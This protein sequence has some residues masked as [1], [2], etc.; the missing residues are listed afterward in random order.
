MLVANF[1]LPRSVESHTNIPA[2]RED[3]AQEEQK[4]EHAGSDPTV[5]RVW[6]G[7]VKVGLVLLSS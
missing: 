2:L 5:G 6:G 3:D 4:E 7:G 1:Y